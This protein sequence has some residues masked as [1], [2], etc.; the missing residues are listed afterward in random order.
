[1]S[2]LVLRDNKVR[3]TEEGFTLKEVKKVWNNDKT[4]KEKKYF[5]DVITAIFYIYKPRGVFWN[6]SVQERIEKVDRD[7]LPNSKWAELY[8]RDGVEELVKIFIELSYTI[9]EIMIEKVKS[10]AVEFI[11]YLYDIPLSIKK[12][13][14]R[15]EEVLDEE[16]KLFKITVEKTIDIPNIEANKE[17]YEMAVV[18]SRNIKQISDLL[19]IEEVERDREEVL[20]RKYDSRQSNI[21]QPESEQ[22]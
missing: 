22:L 17:A 11:S 15:G 13:I 7:Y 4:G 6:K 1:M 14:K 5:N 16:G 21:F 18:I 2:F 19:H 3:C 12:K 8:K 10:R 20:S 9:N